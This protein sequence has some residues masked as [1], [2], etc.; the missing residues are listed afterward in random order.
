MSDATN[1]EA[2]R[3]LGAA[4]LL[5]DWLLNVEIQSEQT[6]PVRDWITAKVSKLVREAE[7]I[8]RIRGPLICPQCGG[9]DAPNDWRRLPN[10]MNVSPMALHIVERHR[11]DVPQSEINK[12]VALMGVKSSN[13]DSTTPSP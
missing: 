4:P 7:V 12:L 1:G 5:D 10:G 9:V 8:D 2:G 3:G 6:A 11:A 13:G